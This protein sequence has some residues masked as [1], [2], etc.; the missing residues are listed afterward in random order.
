MGDAQNQNDTER[1]LAQMVRGLCVGKTHKALKAIF[2]LPPLH[3]VA[4]Y[5]SLTWAGVYCTTCLV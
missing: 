2:A 5:V 4:L 1:C 3:T